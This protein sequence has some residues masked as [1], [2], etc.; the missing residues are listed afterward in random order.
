MET[1]ISKPCRSE[2]SSISA[3]SPE[4]DT[5]KNPNL[6][7]V[8]RGSHHHHHHHHHEPYKPRSGFDHYHHHRHQQQQQQ[9][10]HHDDQVL[11]LKLF[12]M[13]SSSSQVM[14]KE[15][16]SS[17]S[18]HHESIGTAAGKRSSSKQR[19]FS[20]SFCNKNFS[21]S[22]AL[23]GHQNAHKQER[24][25][26]KR[27]KDEI[28]MGSSL[29]HHNHFPYYNTTY[30]TLSNQIPSFYG[31]FN[32]SSPSSSSSPLGVS[33]HS[34]IRKPSYPWIPL[35]TSDRFSHGNKAANMMMM[36]NS[37]K[38]QQLA[39]NNNDHK[40]RLE[41]IIQQAQ[42]SGGGGGVGGS[43]DFPNFAS[44][45]I[46]SNNAEN[47]RASNLVEFLK[48]KTPLQTS[49]NHNHDQDDSA[50]LDLSLKL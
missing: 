37:T 34:M 24:A 2:N 22:Q 11:E 46:D 29:G 15:P 23:G 8:V 48:E 32:R 43:G 50:G 18:I 47:G 12:T 39:Y 41:G 33:M 1:L 49:N 36:M 7:E 4:E 5:K 40:L 45:I 6:E 14:I 30:S 3:A 19:G 20:C 44:S 17:S 13:D 28:H 25:L 9:Q 35:S 31:S 27:R 21:T 16:V 26:A 38:Q 42:K 10:Q